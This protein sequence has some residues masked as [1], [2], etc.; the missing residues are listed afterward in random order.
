M[1]KRKKIN[2]EQP[3]LVDFLDLLGKNVAYGAVVYGGGGQFGGAGGGAS[4][5]GEYDD[6]DVIEQQQ[7]QQQGTM[8][9]FY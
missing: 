6:K 1:K 8:G 3:E 7:Q 4:W 5:G 2:Y 9:V